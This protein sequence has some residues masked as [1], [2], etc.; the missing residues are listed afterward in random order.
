MDI[1]GS[2]G[3]LATGTPPTVAV[4]LGEAPPIVGLA[5]QA[6]VGLGDG[7]SEGKGSDSFFS[8]G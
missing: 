4:D 5:Q 1:G 3:P 6:S 8:C 7:G 2:G